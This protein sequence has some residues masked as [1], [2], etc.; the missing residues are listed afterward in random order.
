MVQRAI[1]RK[2]T[3][4]D[5][6]EATMTE[7]SAMW[8]LKVLIFV[9]WKMWTRESNDW[10]LKWK[11][12]DDTDKE[13]ERIEY[14][15]SSRINQLTGVGESYIKFGRVLFSVLMVILVVVLVQPLPCSVQFR[16]RWWVQLFALGAT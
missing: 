5:I 2:E 16:L 12:M 15:D 11:L 6:L 14:R 7:F 4:C 3:S 10:R 8:S 1:T 13:V 9:W